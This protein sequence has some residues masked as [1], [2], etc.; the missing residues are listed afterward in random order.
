MKLNSILI[1]QNK[2]DLVKETQAKE[3]YRQIIDFVRGFLL[4]SI[5]FDF[6]KFK[7]TKIKHRY[8]C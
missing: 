1:L 3:Q 2:I 6:Q 8:E 4:I 7:K 5:N